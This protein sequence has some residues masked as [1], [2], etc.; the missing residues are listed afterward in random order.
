MF[1]QLDSVP[2]LVVSSAAMAKEVLRTHDLTFASRPAL[3]ATEKLGYNGLSI[4]LAP[5]GKYW[6][7]VR[8]IALV[9]F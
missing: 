6:R 7:E 8:K 2:T 5:Y 1:L 3:Y 4:S 9:E